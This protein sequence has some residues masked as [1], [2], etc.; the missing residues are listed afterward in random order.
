MHKAYVHQIRHAYVFIIN[1]SP[2]LATSKTGIIVI[3]ILYAASKAIGSIKPADA[4]FRSNS[5]IGFVSTT[6]VLVAAIDSRAIV[7]QVPITLNRWRPEAAR[8]NNRVRPQTA[9]KCPEDEK[10]RI[11][12]NTC[13]SPFWAASKHGFSDYS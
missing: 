11:R 4:I 6:V 5:H 1:T 10:R 13:P 3:V 2:T 9:Q 12:E 8:T 7:F